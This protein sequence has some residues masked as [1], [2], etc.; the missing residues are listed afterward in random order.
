MKGKNKPHR[1][2]FPVIVSELSRRSLNLY[3]CCFTLGLS[4]AMLVFLFFSVSS[5]CEQI[6]RENGGQYDCGVGIGW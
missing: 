4:L 3:G 5:R 1:V 2:S 6:F